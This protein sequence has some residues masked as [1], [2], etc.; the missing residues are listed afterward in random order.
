MKKQISLVMDE[1]EVRHLQKF[2]LLRKMKF[3]DCLRKLLKD[4]SGF[5]S[6]NLVINPETMSIDQWPKQ[7]NIKESELAEAFY[8]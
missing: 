1:K 8:G 6:F 5:D 2:A 3:S 4:G 7:Q